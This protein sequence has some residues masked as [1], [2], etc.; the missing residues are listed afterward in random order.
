MCKKDNELLIWQEME[1]VGNKRNVL[2]YF[3]FRPQEGSVT[4]CQ[5]ET[6]EESV[7]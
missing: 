1:R 2:P 5:R 3:L 7:D 4:S 6:V